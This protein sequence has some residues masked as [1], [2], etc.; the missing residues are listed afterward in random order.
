MR[1]CAASLPEDEQGTGAVSFDLAIC[2]DIIRGYCQ[3]GAEL[4]SDEEFTWLPRAIWLLPLELAIRFLADFLAGNG[5]FKTSYAT[6]NLDRARGQLA[7]VQ[8]I[9]D[10]YD[11]LQGLLEG[12]GAA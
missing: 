3:Q 8:A 12:V 2:R 1:S 10:K 5:Y 7:L 4:L 9:E 6:Q 11:R